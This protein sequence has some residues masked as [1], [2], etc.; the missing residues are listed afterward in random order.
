MKKQFKDDVQIEMRIKSGRLCMEAGVTFEKDM[1]AFSVDKGI[2]EKQLIHL[3]GSHM[4][5]L[6]AAFEHQRNK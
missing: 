4:E 6:I 2:T 1:L 5:A 3:L